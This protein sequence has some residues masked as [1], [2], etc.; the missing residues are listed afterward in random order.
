MAFDYEN[1]ILNQLN[2]AKASLGYDDYIIRVSSERR[3]KMDKTDK[4]L[5]FIIKRLTGSYVFN[6]K[7][8]PVQI[9][10]YSELN[11][12]TVGMQ[13]LDLFTKNHNN[14]S[15]TLDSDYIKQNY[16]TVVTLRPM[17]QS[18][19]G[20]KASLYCYG[21]YV[22]CDG[23]A[24]LE[25]LQWLNAS[26]VYKDINY[27]TA[28]I[29]YAAVLNTTKVSGETISTSEKQ[30]AGLTLSISIMNDNSDFCKKVNSIMLGGTH[31]KFTFSYKMN[32]TTYTGVQF[33]LSQATFTT[34]KTDAPGLQLT[35]TR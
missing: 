16:D 5:I 3:F 15:F 29:G 1:Y 22:I 2:I 25:D 27:I 7:T 9:I 24:D 26:S 20:F 4:T 32:G 23:I 6:I 18:E 12:M 33:V 13:I 10:C 14:E 17:I 30:E 11:T 8:Q 31:S 19:V 21:S 28:G 34:N 35:F